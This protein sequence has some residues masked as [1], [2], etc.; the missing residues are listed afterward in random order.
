LLRPDVVWFEEALPEAE[1]ER[2]GAASA[3]CDVFFSIGTAAVVYPAAALPFEAL[4]NGA[5]LVEINPQPT[6]L[7]EQAHFVLTGS[8]GEL[9]PELLR[10]LRVPAG[11]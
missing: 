7:T 4:R 3:G 11:T 5:L 2:A 8:A 6:P 1:M 9:L 10:A